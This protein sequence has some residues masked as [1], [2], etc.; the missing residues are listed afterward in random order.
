[1][2]ILKIVMWLVSRP[3]LLDLVWELYEAMKDLKLTKVEMHGLAKSMK[4]A[5]KQA[6]K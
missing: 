1:M 6:T 2:K 5:I 4:R 3:A